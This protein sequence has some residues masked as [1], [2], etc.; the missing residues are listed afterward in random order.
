MKRKAVPMF[1]YNEL[2]PT[3][4]CRH[5]SCCGMAELYELYDGPVDALASLAGWQRG[6]HENDQEGEGGTF[7]PLVVFSDNHARNGEA[8][9]DYITGN[10]LGTV[11]VSGRAVYNQNS[12]NRVKAWLWRINTKAW[13]K[14]VDT[15]VTFRTQ[16]AQG[17]G[18][19]P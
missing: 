15:H 14:W 3:A 17:W 8:L 4:M 16:N 6:M 1:N 11:V 19:I 7:K 18:A 2:S 9:A 13:N 10:R 12:G 5:T